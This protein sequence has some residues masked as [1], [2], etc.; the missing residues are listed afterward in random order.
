MFRLYRQAGFVEESPLALKNFAFVEQV[1]A[2]TAQAW[3]FFTGGCQPAIML[4]LAAT[5]AHH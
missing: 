3:H 5:R 2:L 4:T 1:T